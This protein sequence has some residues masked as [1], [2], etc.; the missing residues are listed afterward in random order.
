MSYANAEAAYLSGNY[1]QAATL[2]DEVLQSHPEDLRARLLRGH[3][4]CYG[5]KHYDIARS[6]YESIIQQAED[7]VYLA[8]ASEGLDKC[9]E[10]FTL[11]TTVE[12]DL[13]FTETT[14]LLASSGSKT[15]Q[16]PSQTIALGAGNNPFLEG[17]STS[18]TPPL[19]P[20]SDN[21]FDLMGSAI[22]PIAPDEDPL[23]ASENPFVQDIPLENGAG[24]DIAAGG[25]PA[26]GPSGWKQ[27]WS[28]PL[29][30]ASLGDLGSQQPSEYPLVVQGLAPRETVNSMDLLSE[31][32]WPTDQPAVVADSDS[33]VAAQDF[34][35]SDPTDLLEECLELTGEPLTSS[36]PSE[37]FAPESL[38][39][40]D[41][42]AIARQGDP[43][44][45][46]EL[47]PELRETQSQLGG[48]DPADL[49]GELFQI[50][51]G[52]VSHDPEGLAKPAEPRQPPQLTTARSAEFQP[53]GDDTAFFISQARPAPSLPKEPDA[54]P[55]LEDAFAEFEH[56]PDPINLPAL[57]PEAPNLSL[58]SRPQPASLTA[59]PQAKRPHARVY[60]D[61]ML[62]I[63][64]PALAAVA[65]GVG[66][67][68][69]IKEGDRPRLLSW[70]LGVALVGSGASA[71]L[72][73][74][75]R[76]QDATTL[77]AE[78][79]ELIQEH[80]QRL[81]DQDFTT[82]TPVEP[83]DE[84]GS[85][86]PLLNELSLSLGQL[87]QEQQN[88]ITALEQQRQELQRQV[89]RLLDDVEGAARGDLTVRA[90]VTA[91]V[92]GAVADSFNLTIQNLRE[93]VE[94]VKDASHHLSH[95]AHEDEA[96]A[97]SLSHDALQQAEVLVATLGMV[98][99]MS[100]SIQRVADNAREAEVVARAASE[101]ALKGGEAVDQTVSGILRIRK[102]VAETTRKVK[103][104][105]ESSQEISKIV[106]LISQI[107][108]RT[109]L[110]ALNA[111]IQAAQAGDAGRGFANI[112]DEVRQL[113]DRAAKSSREIE[114]IVFQIQG[115]TSQ[116][117]TAMEEGTQQVIEGTRL[118]EQARKNL[119][120]IIQ[121]SQRIDELVRSITADTV[122]QSDTACTMTQ[123]MQGVE[124]TAQHTSQEAQRMASSLK[125]LVS[126]AQELQIS[127]ER[128]QVK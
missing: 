92:L 42:G 123:K 25:R 75:S 74:H 20:S 99:R 88:R 53:S 119:D 49:P 102:T 91:D 43:L 28:M 115:E 57:L 40:T 107:A 44:V 4:Y 70:M 66:V 54:T 47:S 14:V 1:I 64:L 84:L 35:G 3:I 94:Q 113:S 82:L 23:A 128:F 124:Q 8:H 45:S 27:G 108:S 10:A 110:L 13:R 77:R 26:A 41:W 114:T 85:L 81:K 33:S 56:W 101:T 62:P 73:R 68:G 83:G 122:Q 24:Q 79:L 97:S 60:Q 126:V 117:M 48:N 51:A 18:V 32:T 46:N 80:C 127:V 65:V 89:I 61:Q 116:V 15:P 111:S 106:A 6:E 59:S 39:P 98:Q 63:L 2:V 69:Q 78:S 36:S 29:D 17:I 95:E 104:L 21:P 103:R 55:Q 19:E 125:H 58:S 120:A 38:D 72:N 71:V 93:I 30:V 52:G 31:N 86:K 34:A 100:E 7:P 96:F 50:Q 87:T 37:F 118:A 109:N 5:L 12:N 11:A 9:R 76:P 67:S 121:V 90:E 22:L 112:A 16:T 105:A